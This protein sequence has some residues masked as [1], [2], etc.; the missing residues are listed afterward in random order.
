M[1]IEDEEGE[2]R[3]EELGPEQRSRGKTEF[4][5]LLR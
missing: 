2:E 5:K 1:R 4:R 3:G